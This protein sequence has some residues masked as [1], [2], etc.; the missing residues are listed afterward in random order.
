MTLSGERHYSSCQPIT[1]E[2]PMQLKFE[3]DSTEGIN[4]KLDIP[5][6]NP[7][8]KRTYVRIDG[9]NMFPNRILSTPM[10]YDLHNKNKW[11]PAAFKAPKFLGQEQMTPLEI[12]EKRNEHFFGKL[13]GAIEDTQKDPKYYA[14]RYSLD[15][16]NRIMAGLEKGRQTLVGREHGLKEG[17]VALIR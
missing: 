3:I 9:G 5:P 11:K 17:K 16:V 1:S 7:H 4:L 14:T 12:L 8:R 10:V 13:L 2:V 6:Q 15:R